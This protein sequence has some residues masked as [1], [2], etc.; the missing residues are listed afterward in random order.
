MG[1]IQ[2]DAIIVTGDVDDIG[3]IH[4]V[5]LSLELLVSDIVKARSNG[6][7]SFL[8][9]PDGSKEG[10]ETSAIFESRRGSFIDWYV[11]H[12]KSWRWRVVYVTFGELAESMTIVRHS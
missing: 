5:A 2:H 1:I 8:I 12:E 9:A 6:Y 11:K 10:W 3:E 7:A 4:D